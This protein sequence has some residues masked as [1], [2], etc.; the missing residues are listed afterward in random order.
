MRI[1]LRSMTIAAFLLSIISPSVVSA[2]ESQTNYNAPGKFL[3]NEPVIQNIRDFTDTE[4]V[5]LAIQS[6][7]AL[8][9]DI[10]ES[11]I[12]KLDQAWRGETK[13]DDQPLISA[14]LS[15]P[16]SSYLTRVQAHSIG[17]YTE[18]FVMDKNGL[19][20]GQSNISS[21]YWQ[22]DEAKFQKTYQVGPNTV[23][24]DEPEYKDDLGLWVAQVNMSIAD[25]DG[26]KIG[27]ITTEINLNELARRK[28]L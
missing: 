23:F 11:E 20:V 14:K 8:L 25:E 22:G 5:R 17:L 7:N 26:K 10:S 2:Q 16:L 6:Q 4:I 13:S 27:A 9:G 28:A 3:I 19:N 21:D 1:T 15:S 24:I 18:I 12:L